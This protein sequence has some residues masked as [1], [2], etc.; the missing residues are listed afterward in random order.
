MGRDVL[1][2]HGVDLAR[3]HPEE[4]EDPVQRDDRDQQPV[5]VPADWAAR[6]LEHGYAMTCHK[7][8]GATAEIALLYGT[9]ALT[10]EAGYVALSRGRT[11]NHLYVPDDHDDGPNALVDNGQHLDRLAA[12]LAVRRGQTLATRQLPRLR[13]NAWRTSVEHPTRE[14]REGLS[15]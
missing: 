3:S 1:S 9:G 15:R 10:R 11:A 7:A 14:R 8:Q 13:P 2:G 5:T 12:R 4:T 6:H